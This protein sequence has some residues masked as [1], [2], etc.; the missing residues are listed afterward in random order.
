MIW[1]S[2]CAWQKVA[3][4]RLTFAL[5]HFSLVSP[6]REASDRAI[7]STA[8]TCK[9]NGVVKSR[10]WVSSSEAVSAYC[11]DYMGACIAGPVRNRNGAVSFCHGRGWRL[12]TLSQ[13]RWCCHGDSR[14]TH[15]LEVWTIADDL[16]ALDPIS[17]THTFV[18]EPGAEWSEALHWCWDPETS[19]GH[20]FESC[21]TCP[22][23]E[24]S[25]CW[26]GPANE[27]NCCRFTGMLFLNHSL[28]QVPECRSSLVRLD[29]TTSGRLKVPAVIYEQLPQTILRDEGCFQWDKIIPRWLNNDPLALQSIGLP[30]GSLRLLELGAGIGVLTVVL[31]RR[32]HTVFAV[33]RSQCILSFGAKNV[34]RNLAQ[35]QRSKV[36]LN[37]WDWTEQNWPWANMRFDAVF[38]TGGVFYEGMRAARELRSS[39][40]RLCNFSHFVVLQLSH[41]AEEKE[42]REVIGDFKISG[43]VNIF[44]LMPSAQSTVISLACD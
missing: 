1:S 17:Q 2:L 36:S 24:S 39:L 32:N 3:V 13:I 15:T 6:P 29:G 30:K 9:G 20:S 43:K 21:C 44:Y 31:A 38:L 41:H 18:Y 28:H 19:Q 40:H 22:S 8:E 4:C 14:Q 35:H 23:A 10:R 11:C 37:R 25:I 26:S 34:E 42:M 33:D 7:F 12:C 27:E 5:A 16:A